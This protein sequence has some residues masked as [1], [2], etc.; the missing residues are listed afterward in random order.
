MYG[1]ALASQKSSK[2]QQVKLFFADVTYA[3]TTYYCREPKYLF[4]LGH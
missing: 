4:S 2:S 1:K 3:T